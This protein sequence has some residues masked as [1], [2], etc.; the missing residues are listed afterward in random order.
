MVTEGL[1]RGV[2]TLFSR[3]CGGYGPVSSAVSA[4]F[5]L[6]SFILFP[7]MGF[8]NGSRDIWGQLQFSC[9]IAHSGKGLISLFQGFSASID[10]AFILVGRLGT[11]LSFS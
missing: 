1:F 2:Q 9:E 6:T 11:K 8:Y 7:L 10:K 4:Y 5:S 3:W